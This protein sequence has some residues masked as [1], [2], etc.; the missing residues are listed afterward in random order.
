MATLYHQV[1][2]DST[3]ARLYEAIATESGIARWWDAPTAKE[4]NAGSVLEFSPG[5]EHGVLQMKVVDR[6]PGNRVEW[7][8][9]S[10]HPS[11]S[12]ASAWTGTHISFDISERQ[13]NVA[14]SG[15]GQGTDRIA[16][17]DFRHSGWDEDSEYLGFCNF[18]WGQ[19]LVQL[20]Q[21]CES[22]EQ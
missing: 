14:L 3:P 22:P 21:L 11:S 17:V 7:E 12:P 20:K 10:K 15:Y 5:A 19:A 1:W 18:A 9:I 16:I 13:N 2:I 8:C 4:T 6:R